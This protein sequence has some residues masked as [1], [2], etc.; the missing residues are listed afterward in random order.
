[1]PNWQ[2]HWDDV[3]F[4]H[5]ETNEAVVL[6]QGALAT[7]ADRHGAL[8]GPYHMACV[9]WRGVKRYR[10]DAEWGAM[11]AQAETVAEQL[12]THIVKLRHESAVALAEQRLREAERA[13]WFR[14]KA[15]EEAA[16]AAALEATRIAAQQ[17]A[18]AT[19]AAA[20][21]AAQNAA[22]ASAAASSSSLPLSSTSQTVTAK[23]A[24]IFA[25]ITSPVSNPALSAVG[26]GSSPLP[27]PT[28][29]EPVN[30]VPTFTPA[31]TSR[32]S[33]QISGR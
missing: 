27:A 33:G 22:A 31:P 15:V 29:F 6:C 5:G 32:A 25:L 4:D 3:Q 8:Q 26:S 19:Q 7:L 28:T 1:M 9:H 13:R 23:P 10:F 20:I 12:R 14:E 24:L 30:P 17:A 18:A 16:A 21:Q 2:P 11:H